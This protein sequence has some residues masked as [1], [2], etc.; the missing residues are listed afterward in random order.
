MRGSRHEMTAESPEHSGILWSALL[1]LENSTR[2]S[3][4]P[5]ENRV[6]LGQSWLT[7]WCYR[8]TDDLTVLT[9][10]VWT[11]GNNIYVQAKVMVI[12]SNDLIL[13][14]WGVVTQDEAFEPKSSHEQT[15]ES[16]ELRKTSH[17]NMIYVVLQ[18]QPGK[19][20]T[21]HTMD[22]FSSTVYKR[23]ATD[24]F[25]L[26]FVCTAS[27][28]FFQSQHFCVG[29]ANSPHLHFFFSRAVEFETKAKYTGPFIKPNHGEERVDEK[30]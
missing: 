13:Y 11:S 4:G 17:V 28:S 2:P 27:F 26:L 10:H 19:L 16:S 21:F 23:W 7:C 14:L 29:V 24:L 15:F 30:R 22:R 6:L 5:I 18:T 12:N 25:L 20:L 8:S 3:L 1:W 9:Q